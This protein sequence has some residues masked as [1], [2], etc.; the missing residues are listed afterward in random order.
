MNTRTILSRILRSTRFLGLQSRPMPLNRSKHIIANKQVKVP[1][2][3]Q[4]FKGME[5]SFPC[6]TELSPRSKGSIGADPVYSQVLTGFQTF[7]YNQPFYFQYNEGVVPEM[8]VAYETWGQLND[9]KSN[10]VL[11]YTG[12]SASSHARS[13]EV[14]SID[15]L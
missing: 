7:L 8:V 12:L 9:D 1:D 3:V 14:L 4:E 2:F 15:F 11:L 6:L 10:V 13:N 5:P